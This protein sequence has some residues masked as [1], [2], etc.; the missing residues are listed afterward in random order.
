MSRRWAPK[1]EKD[2]GDLTNAIGDKLTYWLKQITC[3][4]RKL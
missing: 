3:S 2:L 1:E 4:L